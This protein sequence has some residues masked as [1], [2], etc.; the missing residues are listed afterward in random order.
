[1][2]VYT[3]DESAVGNLEAASK[4]TLPTNGGIAFVFRARLPLPVMFRRCRE[5][6]RWRQRRR[7]RWNG[8]RNNLERLFNPGYSLSFADHGKTLFELLL[9]WEESGS[10][11]PTSAVETACHRLPGAG[12]RVV[13]RAGL[14]AAA[15]EELPDLVR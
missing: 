10:S 14:G 1:M 3:C 11:S 2:Q 8:N 6:W 7:A 4:A 13:G 12:E 5:I 9:F 15:K